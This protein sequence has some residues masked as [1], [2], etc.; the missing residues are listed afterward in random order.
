[1]STL[2]A[3]NGYN[4]LTRNDGRLTTGKWWNNGR[5]GKTTVHDDSTADETELAGT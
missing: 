3:L 1:L 2:N 5:F 4:E